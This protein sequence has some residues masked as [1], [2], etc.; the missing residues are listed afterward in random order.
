MLPDIIHAGAYSS[1]MGR[2]IREHDYTGPFLGIE[3]DKRPV[4]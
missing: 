4:A 1:A 2:A 3:P